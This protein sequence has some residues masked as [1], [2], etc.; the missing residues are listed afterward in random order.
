MFYNIIKLLIFAAMNIEL[1]DIR[2]GRRAIFPVLIKGDGYNI[3]VDASYPGTLHR[4][5]KAI[6]QRGVSMEELTHVVVTHHDFDH[7]GSLAAL[8]RKYPHVQVVASE[9]EAPYIAGKKKSL[10]LRQAEDLFHSLPE[11]E[12]PQALRFQH[13]LESV[14][15]VEVDRKVKNGDLIAQ[16]VVVVETPGHTPG[17]ISLYMPDNKALVAGDALVFR[18]E[19]LE[20]ANPEYTLD[21]SAALNSIKLISSLNLNTILCYHGGA[22]TGDCAEA[23]QYILGI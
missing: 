9:Q 3:L 5:E 18:N 16:G 7:I 19:R 14:E 4:I 8:K 22:Y 23:L 20:I 21:M 11:E 10:R 6:M 17:H 15:T 2:A 13:L 12:R 1:L